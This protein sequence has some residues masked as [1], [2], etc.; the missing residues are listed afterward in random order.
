MLLS[1]PVRKM[2]LKVATD[3]KNE[4]RCVTKNMPKILSSRLDM[5]QPINRRGL[6]K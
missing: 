3:E 1:E 5:G 4:I 6:N 2:H